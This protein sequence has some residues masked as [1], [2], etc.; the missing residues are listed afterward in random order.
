MYRK[1]KK[2]HYFREKQSIK[3]LIQCIMYLGMTS[4]IFGQLKEKKNLLGFRKLIGFTT[5]AKI[6]E[7]LIFNNIYLYTGKDNE[8]VHV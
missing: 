7:K 8:D 5:L 2:K 4:T 1:K 6:E 3:S